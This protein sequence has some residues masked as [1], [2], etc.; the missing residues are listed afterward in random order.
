[1]RAGRSRWKIENETFNTLK[2]QGYNFEHNYGHGKE[3]LCTNLVL[4]MMLAFFVDQLQQLLNPLFQAAW[5]KNQ[6]KIALWEA[7]RSKFNEFVVDAMEM[8]CRLIIGQ[9]KV[10]YEFYEDSG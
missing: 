5:K 4:L 7:V 6:S 2:N 1:M 3:N 10:R 8:I 9:L